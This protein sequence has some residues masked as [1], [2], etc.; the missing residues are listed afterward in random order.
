MSPPA[1]ALRFSADRGGA[2]P[3][4]HLAGCQGYLQAD[5]FAGYNTLYRDRRTKAPRDIV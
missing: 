4:Q 5:G 2:H 3:A 1:E